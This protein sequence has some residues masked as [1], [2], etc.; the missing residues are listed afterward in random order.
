MTG[1]FA[2]KSQQECVLRCPRCEIV[3]SNCADRDGETVD[4]ELAIEPNEG[5]ILRPL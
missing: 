4:G 5:L 1:D 2:E 3:L